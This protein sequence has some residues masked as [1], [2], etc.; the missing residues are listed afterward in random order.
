MTF[1]LGE[2]LSMLLINRGFLKPTVFLARGDGNTSGVS[3]AAFTTGL[4]RS[5]AD[6]LDGGIL[7]APAAAYLVTHYAA[8]AAAF[9]GAG[10]IR[11]FDEFGAEFSDSDKELIE[12]LLSEKPRIYN[13]DFGRLYNFTDAVNTY[14]HI[15]MLHHAH[16]DIG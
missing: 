10:G 13:S 9:V 11:F 14:K 15:G 1:A 16:I 5:G 7:P 4:L 6:V 3:A 12:S 2:A 8:H